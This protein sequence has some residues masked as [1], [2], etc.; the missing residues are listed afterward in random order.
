M[1]Y[2][3][4]TLAFLAFALSTMAEPAQQPNMLRLTFRNGTTV[5][6]E[7]LISSI[8]YS[9]DGATLFLA[10]EGGA[11]VDYPTADLQELTMFHFDTP[12][13]I[14]SAVSDQEKIVIKKV[15]DGQLFI[16]RDGHIY[17]ASGVRVQ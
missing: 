9:N 17:N 14:Q 11:T 8:T 5:V 3:L 15:I 1:K 7:L 4:S 12:T 2:I 16:D 6:Q 13:E 10:R